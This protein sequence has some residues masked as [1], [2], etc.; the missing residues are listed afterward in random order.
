MYV[1]VIKL[2]SE[3]KE[4]FIFKLPQSTGS[5]FTLIKLK[6]SYPLSHC[7]SSCIYGAVTVHQETLFLVSQILYIFFCDRHHRENSLSETEPKVKKSVTRLESH[8]VQPPI[9]SQHPDCRITGPPP[10]QPQLSSVLRQTQVRRRF[11]SPRTS[12]ET[13]MTD[14]ESRT[15]PGVYKI[16]FQVGLR[17]YPSLSLKKH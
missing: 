7:T 3:R 14:T 13:E 9:L 10:H 2:I 16:V 15:C 17:H 1:I 12:V 11:V 6:S 8:E 4:A 5:F